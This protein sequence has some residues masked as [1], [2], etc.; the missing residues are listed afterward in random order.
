[1]VRILFEPLGRGGEAEVG[2][3]ILDV[4]VRLGVGLRSECGG[5]V[6]CGKCRIIVEGRGV[7]GVE[8]VESKRLSAEELARGYRLAC[9]AKILPDARKITVKV[10][11]ESI[12]R[13]RKFVGDGVVRRVRLDPLVLQYVDGAKSN[14]GAVLGVAVDV[15][16]SR[17][18]AR[19]IDLT[20]GATLS[21][22]SVENPQIAYGENL[23]TRAAYAQRSERHRL[24]LRAELLD[25]I[26]TLI[27]KLV[28]KNGEDIL[29]AV[30][31]GNT[32]M[33][34]LLLGLDTSR[35][36]RAP[37]TPTRKEMTTLRGAEFGLNINPDA[38]VSL[39][40]NIDAFVG[41]D[42]VA[43]VI[44]GNL[45]R[46]AEPTLLLDI[47]TNTELLLRAGG[48]T[49]A[50]SCA[51]GPAFEGEHIE[52]GMKAV[53][54]AIER[55]RIRRG[56]V[57]FETVGGV[58][59]VGL[60]GSGIVDAVAEL[61]RCGLINKV[62]RFTA[63]T[64][65][66][67]MQTGNHRKFIIANAR[68]S[69]TGSPIT[70]S[71]GDINEIILAKT[72]ISAAAEVLMEMKGIEARDLKRV[73]VAGA[74]GGHLNK[75]NAK[76]IGLLPDVEGRRIEFIGNSALEGASMALKS[77]KILSKSESIARETRYV[78]LASN[79][80]FDTRFRKSIRLP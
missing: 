39:L 67:L 33:H 11:P 76:R 72:A 15:G 64:T 63:A 77:R 26:N 20:S 56:V 8:A 38:I 5:A 22:E 6:S 80:D 27:G 49:L 68:E 34:H 9:A 42:A 54:G 7:S 44:A 75:V 79:P 59:P 30:L 13:A 2:E 35:L 10:P 50:C 71:E 29:Q 55:V 78:E 60:C 21:T 43:D 24:K 74:F 3:S 66:N 31:V 45:L 4:V 62:G 17:V 41:A 19:L 47:G 16:T 58:A 40:P 14:S 70:L 61:L 51:S 18:T 65:P 23:I 32:V 36:T 37:F 52:H 25:T 69:G 12:L 73:L 1:M 57:T 46:R 28:E 48:E 53:E